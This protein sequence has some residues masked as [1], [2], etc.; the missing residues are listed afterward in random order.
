GYGFL[1]E[2]PEFAEVCEQADVMFVGPRPEV[3]RVLGNKVAARALA[4]SVGVRT[5]PATGPLPRDLRQAQEIAAQIGYPLMLKA[6]WG[7]GGRG[8][9]VV[10]SARELAALID[11]ARR[12]ALAAFGNDEVYLEKFVRR[13]HH[14]E[15]QILG[16]LHGTLVHLFERDCSVQRR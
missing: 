11:G 7:G 12:E 15:V 2:K 14:V 6:S 4:H 1:A 5:L 9:R 16:D 8:M 13:A 10:E 3:L